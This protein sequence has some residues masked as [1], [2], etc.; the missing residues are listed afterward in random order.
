MNMKL[1]GF[2]VAAPMS[3]ITACFD[4]DNEQPMDPPIEDPTPTPVTPKT[5]PPAVYTLTNDSGD[6]QITVF[7]R[8]ADGSLSR[9]ASYSTGGTGT[10]TGLGDQGS[11]VYQAATERLFAINAGDHSISMLGVQTDGSLKLLAKIESG[12]RLPVSVTVNKDLLY[13]VNEG[14]AAMAIPGNIAGFRIAG[15]KL[16]A[17]AGSMRPLSVANPDVA[18]ISF[19]PAG[20]VLVVTEKSS[21]NIDTYVVDGN[22]AAGAPTIT[23]SAGAT[24]FGFTFSTGGQLLVS[25]AAGGM[26]N[27]STVSSYDVSVTGKL[28]AVSS[29]VPTLQTAACWMAYANGFV[30]S[31]NT[32]SAT[33]TGYSVALNGSLA[34]MKAD[35]ISGLAGMTPAD[36]AMSPDGKTLYVM[37]L[38]D[39]TISIFAVNAD[40]SLTKK[41][42]FDA[43]PSSAIGI[44]VR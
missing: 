22:G 27:A 4:G 3:L 17:I 18:Q 19:T 44:A 2:L 20:G 6:N 28:T 25:E 33:V 37:N 42:D 12:G 10:S 26:P 14:D 39:D 31:A 7:M 13:V 40:G 43:V 8:D 5:A 35:G 11:L 1:L 15:D 21:N 24:P 32:G 41:S 34:R 29:A 9:F 36:E 38:R 16:T 30:Y 23:T